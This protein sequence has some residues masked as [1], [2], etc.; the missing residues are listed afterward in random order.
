[1][2]D[3][4]K[5]SRTSSK[6]GKL[7]CSKSFRISWITKYFF[8]QISAVSFL[9]LLF[10]EKIDSLLVN[11]RKISQFKLVLTSWKKSKQNLVKKVFG[12][13]QKFWWSGSCKHD[14][15]LRFGINGNL[16]K[17]LL[18]GF[19]WSTF[20]NYKLLIESYSLRISHL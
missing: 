19:S 16:L 9:C 4:P 11:E 2:S 6:I 1:M 15:D 17:Y 5:L 8:N 18:G 10:A 20:W 12:D 7:W 13:H 14:I 3:L